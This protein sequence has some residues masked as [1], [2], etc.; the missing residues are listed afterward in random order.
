MSR[1]EKE[2]IR[3]LKK[4]GKHIAALRTLLPLDPVADRKFRELDSMEQS[5]AVLSD[6]RKGPKAVK[7]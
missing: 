5:V 3:R 1:E 6:E 4:V 7:G 2:W